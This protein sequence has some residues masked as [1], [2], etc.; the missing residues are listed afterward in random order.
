MRC[1]FNRQNQR[2]ITELQDIT[3]AMKQNFAE[4]ENG[5]KNEF[6]SIREELKNKNLEAKHALRVELETAV[7]DLWA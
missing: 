3:F 6:Q 5:A 2:E 1:W 4:R 7:E